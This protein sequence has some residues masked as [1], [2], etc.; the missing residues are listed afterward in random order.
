MPRYKSVFDR[1]SIFD[2]DGKTRDN[3][4]SIDNSDEET[5]EDEEDEVGEDEETDEGKDKANSS[6]EE[7]DDVGSDEDKDEE[8]IIM[9]EKWAKPTYKDVLPYIV[10]KK[11]LKGNLKKDMEMLADKWH[12]A[13]L[14]AKA[15]PRTK[16]FKDFS[17][18]YEKN[19]KSMGK[20]FENDG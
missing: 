18:F 20:Q 11:K 4:D 7:N 19:K 16:F 13:F 1:K 12:S 8:L 14:L 10:D 6:E 2:Q 3:I 9:S 15:V 5:K 17:K